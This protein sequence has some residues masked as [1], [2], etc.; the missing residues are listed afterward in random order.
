[1]VSSDRYPAAP[2]P[3]EDGRHGLPAHRPPSA[4]KTIRGL[5]HPEREPAPSRPAQKRDN[6]THRQRPGTAPELG[7]E[8][9]G[10]CEACGEAAGP[11]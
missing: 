3:I 4:A 8:G 1:M 2:Y 7:S 11:R 5:P 6:G 9:R 10:R